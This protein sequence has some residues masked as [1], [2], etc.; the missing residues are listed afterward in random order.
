MIHATL[1][2]ISPI[3]AAQHIGQNI[4]FKGCGTD[5]R[6]TLTGQ[7]FIALYGEHFDAHEFTEQAQQQGAIALLVSRQVRTT[8]PQLIVKDTRLAL[9]Q[10]A[11]FWRQQ[12]DIPTIAVTGSNGKTTTKE[13]LKAIF[14]QRGQVL[15]TQGN[16]NNDVG[17]PLTLFQLDTQ[18]DS[19]ILEMGANHVGEIGYLS[20]IAQPNVATITQCAPAH[21]EGFKTIENIAT[22]KG[23]IF[24]GL[25]QNGIAVINQDDR[26]ATFWRELAYPHDII[27][28]GLSAQADVSAQNIQTSTTGSQFDLVTFKG[29]IPI[30][31]PLAGQHNIMNALAATACA[32]ASNI[33]LAYIQQGLATT[34]AVTGRLQKFTG[35]CHSTLINDTYNA[36]PT[37][38]KAALSVL[39]HYPAPRWLVM[40]DMKELG[41]NSKNSHQEIADL[42]HQLGVEQ[43]WAIGD[44]S[45]Y[46]VERFQGIAQHFNNHEALLKALKIA[47]MQQSHVTLLIKGSRSMTM[48]K[49]T[50][51][52]IE[53]NHA[54]LVK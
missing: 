33:D 46:A 34:Q 20:Q 14:T 15:A 3:L 11:H 8:L 2:Q 13:I 37:S 17:L 18:H 30:Y 26:F 50:F 47:L 29:Q 40:G 35:I 44:Y 23:E 7:L 10:L 22:A 19:A 12:F 4:S 1:S 6:Q 31:L 51:G 36:N 25:T 5:T 41:L 28:F 43:L 16:F 39:Q 38:F 45:R 24:S 53:G 54:T 48:E 21:L 42:A 49:I 32:L 52:L 9:G 27:Q